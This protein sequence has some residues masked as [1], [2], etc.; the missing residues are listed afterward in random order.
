MG[1]ESIQRE[2]A[3]NPTEPGC[4]F[5]MGPTAAVSGRQEALDGYLGRTGRHCT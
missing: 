1:T 2:Q 5:S 3:A 4:A